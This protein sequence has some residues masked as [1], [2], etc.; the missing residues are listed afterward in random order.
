[1]SEVVDHLAELTRLRDREVLDVTLAGAINE[2][3]HPL[4]VAIYR[5]VGEP[6]NERWATRA[7]HVAGAVAAT[8]DSAWV[9]I[10]T[11]PPVEDGG[12][13]SEV[14]ASRGA[15][16]VAGSTHLGVFPLTTDRDVVGVLEVET[17]QALDLPSQRLVGGILRI[18]H[19]F[20]ALLDY[21]ERDTL[22]GLLNRKTFD[23]TF[24]KATAPARADA[25]TGTADRRGASATPGYWL[26]LIDID[27]FKRVNDNFGH[28]IG[29][30]V[31]LLVARLMRSTFR[32]HDRLYRFGGEEFLVLMRCHSD[33]DAMQAFE[34]LRLNIAGYAF[35]QVGRITISIG[36]TEVLGGDSPSA[37]FERADLAVYYAK[38][39]GRDQVHSHARLVASG[40]L[41]TSEKLGDVELF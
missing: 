40:D 6:G 18:C 27:H 39:H 14:F 4:S 26:G 1:M 41:V 20:E 11:L 12:P 24:L 38:A 5:K 8:S 34:R 7:R 29:D 31:L 9:D 22:T 28:L 37:A 23:D 2:L 3:L 13:R 36:V 25:L 21:S 10:Q 19:N 16:M 17:A 15:V 32:T 35:P 30:E 33:A